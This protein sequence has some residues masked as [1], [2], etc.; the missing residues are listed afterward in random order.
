MVLH[1][2]FNILL[3][4]RAVDDVVG[5]DFLVRLEVRD[6][7][8]HVVRQDAV[9]AKQRHLLLRASRTLHAQLASFLKT[10]ENPR[11]GTS[12]RETTDHAAERTNAG[13]E[14]G[15]QEDERRAYEGDA[16]QKQ[17][18]QNREQEEVAGGE[19]EQGQQPGAVVEIQGRL[20]LEQRA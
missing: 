20:L 12:K 11:G 10:A 15:T 16:D 6:D 13:L 7:A 14:G 9:P 1:N 3:E 17:K 5:G 8:P 2:L 19:T 4:T 18:R